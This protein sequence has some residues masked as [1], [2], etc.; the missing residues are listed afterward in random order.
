MRWADRIYY[1]EAHEFRQKLMEPWKIG[2]KMVGVKKSAGLLELRIVFK[3]GHL[4]PMDQ[5]EASLDMATSFVNRVVRMTA[6]E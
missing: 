2:D 3:A 1:E 4:V 6:F 5:P